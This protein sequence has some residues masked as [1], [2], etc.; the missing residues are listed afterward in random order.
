[1]VCQVLVVSGCPMGIQRT[2]LIIEFVV[3]YSKYIQCRVM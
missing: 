3:Y 1:M 2:N